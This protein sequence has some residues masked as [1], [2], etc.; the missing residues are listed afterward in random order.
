M[1]AKQITQKLALA[2]ILHIHLSLCPYYVLPGQ[3]Q[4]PWLL[5]SKV[6][7]SLSSVS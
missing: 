7:L 5:A 3:S 4:T 6:L 1:E 2:E